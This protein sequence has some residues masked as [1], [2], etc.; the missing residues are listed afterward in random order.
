MTPT[1]LSKAA[2]VKLAF[3]N[4]VGFSA[5]TAIPLWIGNAGSFGVDSWSAARLAFLQLICAAI[6]NLMTPILAGNLSSIRIA[7]ITAGL[8]GVGYLL[9]A[10]GMP[11]LFEGGLILAGLSL[12]SLLASTNRIMAQSANVHSSFSRTYI[13][14]C[15]FSGTAYLVG[16]IV[17]ALGGLPALFAALAALALI[18]C[19]FMGQIAASHV[20][21]DRSPAA[22]RGTL[23][24]AP[25][26]ALTGFAVLMTGQALVW[27]DA[28]GNGAAIGL[29]AVEVGRVMGGGV[30]AGLVGALVAHAVGTRFGILKPLIAGGAALAASV[31]TMSSPSGML[32]YTIG[33]IGVAT[34]TFIL[35]PY[36]FTLLSGVDRSGRAAAMGPAFLL[37][38][39]SVA[40]YLTAWIILNSSRLATGLGGGGLIMLGVGFLIA[41]H[42]LDI[43]RGQR[44]DVVRYT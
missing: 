12:G 10:S 4:S 29:S 36:V 27:L 17:V 39:N 11:G 16:P 26:I 5:A 38:G 44:S 13:T 37:A 42:A 30:A 22:P 21:I 7:Q 2:V 1:S 43:R 6:A 24:A 8:A 32:S 41:G 34:S 25:A 35:M 15:L 31:A 19:I 28:V 23:N 9:S 40:P 20:P 3:S 33:A 14:E 18:A